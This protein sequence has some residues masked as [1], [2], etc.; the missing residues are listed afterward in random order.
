[1]MRSATNDENADGVYATSGM[2]GGPANKIIYPAWYYWSTVVQRLGNYTPDLVVSESGP[3]WIYQ[4]KNRLDTNKKAWI[5]FSPT[6]NGSLI[7]NFNFKP[8]SAKNH[9]F[10]EI[11]LVDNNASGLARPGKFLNG[12]VELTVGEAPVILVEE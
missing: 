5:L 11:Y 4:L 8:Q 9:S 6:T 10:T 12:S 3:V 2:I 7:K 1:M